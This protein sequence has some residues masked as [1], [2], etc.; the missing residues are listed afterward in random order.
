MWKSKGTFARWARIGRRTF[1]MKLITATALIAV[2]PN[3]LSNI[4]AY[5]KVSHTLEKETGTVKLQYLHQTINAVEIVLNRIRE[6]ARQLALS[7]AVQDFEHFPN[8][9]YYESIQGEIPKE[10]LAT[11][12]SYLATK[13]NA[14][15]T[16]I[17]FKLSNEFVESIFFYDGAKRLVIAAEQDGVYRQFA[18]DDFYDTGWREA[19]NDPAPNPVVMDT[20]MAKPYRGGE[21]SLLTV[22]YKLQKSGDALIVNLDASKMYAEIV[23]KLN[24]GDDIYVASSAGRLLFH[25]DGSH[26]HRPIGEL[27][28]DVEGA[29]GKT[30][31]YAAEVGGGQKR[32]SHSA[33][34]TLGWTF[35]NVSD[36]KALTKG[37]A[38]IKR[39]IVLS[40]I[41]VFALS[42]AFA[43]LSSRTLYRP[44]SRLK[45][46]AGVGKTAE[47]DRR[48]E[49]GDEI[50]TIGR[51]V[52]STMDERDYYKEK[53][54]ES[55]PFHREQ[56]KLS[57]LHR[58]SMTVGD[59][60][61]TMAYLGVRLDSRHLAVL[62]LAAES[63]APRE[64]DADRRTGGLSKLLAMEAIRQCEA[65]DMP[66]AAID[67][68]R[69]TIA[70]VIGC[71]GIDRQQLFRLAQR[72]LD[73]VNRESGGAW[74]MGIG[75]I[76]PTIADLPQA[77][78]DAL[79][80][81]KYRMLY[82]SGHVISIDD[83]R[84]DEASDFRYP[85]LKEEAL[86]GFLKTARTDE[87]LQAFDAFVAEIDAY[88]GKL[89]YN[90]I[91]PLFVQLL[92]AIILGYHQ[93]GADVR[94]VL[95][96]GSN[97]YRELLDLDSMD[98]IG[99]WFRRLIILTTAYFEGEMS[100][101]GNQH[102]AKVIDMIERDYGQDLSLNSVAERLNL[103]PAY[104]SR[105]FKQMTG[106]PFV[107]YLKRVRI[108]RSK[109][110]LLAETGL[111]INEIG[112]RV[113]YN[114][115]YYFIKVFKESMGVTPGEYKKLYGS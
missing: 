56:F 51:F 52:Q 12:Y 1:F 68:G 38:S 2:I 37:T 92:T 3:L 76:C 103:N 42:I 45:A 105:L 79:E 69:E 58:H 109:E 32:I 53:L 67:A 34:A 25:G 91:Q 94:A 11:L 7:Q 75:R 101:K 26:L 4:V 54:A 27:L 70:V 95:G 88:K 83:I 14:F 24:D 73:D 87:A 80:A 36:M 55:L 33:S 50:G 16:M 84:L 48:G 90:R 74:T 59:I 35:F 107:D 62:A 9:L 113:G 64:T 29:I 19:L 31:T 66:Y 57:L 111:K 102:I 61:E 23:N 18:P 85:A 106:Q 47:S 104:I 72:L 114:S 97:P 41:V 46:L 6:N 81:L 49:T 10:D 20:R 89:H 13:T 44:I 8:G 39:T 100:A 110:L 21:K 115:S 71:G 112:R 108:E 22:V 96:D 15:Q 28:P 99:R 65:L 93:L 60:E 43:Y 30:G 77:Y 40:A 98:K 17:S 82:G 78:E 86:L 63:G 5:S